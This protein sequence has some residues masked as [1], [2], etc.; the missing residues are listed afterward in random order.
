M[1]VYMVLGEQLE[2]WELEGLQ[3]EYQQDQEVVENVD[4]RLH[5]AM[6]WWRMFCTSAMVLSIVWQ[7]L[8][9]PLEWWPEKAFFR[10]NKSAM[11]EAEFVDTAVQ[12]LLASNAIMEC[13]DPWVVSPLSVDVKPEKKRL[14][15]DLRYLNKH[16]GV[17]RKKMETLE[18]AKCL[19]EPGALLF[20]IDLKSGYH[21]VPIHPD[22]WKYLAFEWRGKCYQYK[23][24]PFGLNVA[25][26]YFVK[27]LKVLVKKWRSEGIN[28]VLHYIDDLIFSLGTHPKRPTAV[29]KHVM[30]DLKN[31]GMVVNLK[32]SVLEPHT[33]MEAV[34][35][36]IHTTP[37]LFRLPERKLAAIE[38]MARK[39]PERQ[40]HAVKWLAALAG[41]VQS[42]KL[43]LGPMVNVY[44]R[45]LYMLIDSAPTWGTHVRVNAEVRQDVQAILEGIRKWNGQRIE[46]C[47]FKLVAHT[48]ASAHAGGG[49]IEDVWVHEEFDVPM[50]LA[51][52]TLREM[53]ALLLLIR[54]MRFMYKNRRVLFR[55][56]NQALYYIMRKGGSRIEA[57]W[58]ACK[59]AYELLWEARIEWDIE[60][61][62]RHLNTLAD[63]IS[64]LWDC[65]DWAIDPSV[66]Q[67]L[68]SMWG[69]HTVDRMADAHNHILLRY[70]SKFYDA[71][72][73]A[74]D[75]FTQ[76]WWPENN[77]VNPEL[78]SIAAVIRHC[79]W[80]AANMTIVVPMWTGAPWWPLLVESGGDWAMHVV[81]WQVLD[82]G[83]NNF[84]PG[85][86]SKFMGHGPLEFDVV[87]LRVHYADRSREE[88]GI[89]WREG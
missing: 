64:K 29:V 26:F 38:H 50:Q 8:I 24:L 42:S 44:L 45:R 82:S 89:E 11:A 55:V 37:H 18:K 4:K 17:E 39:L 9:L 84:V 76:D 43:A 36:E 75:C 73:E 19:I 65:D 87:A 40:K 25:P 54:K 77:W 2:Q 20:K 66:F 71:N 15:F 27:V 10:N 63:H 80:C 48:D 57:L 5:A 58:A 61:V 60:W 6:P 34:G 88:H 86:H 31:A 32:K 51:S 13:K 74:V 12:E 46:Q 83:Y 35:F 21:H 7:G 85:R 59:E 16:M 49:V 47:T 70:N 69:P 3:A 53:M 14:C 23:V 22:Y 33:V 28:V 1:S 30:Q 78:E 56:D 67:W 62:P 72:A 68:D 41:K 79:R 52:S 81:A